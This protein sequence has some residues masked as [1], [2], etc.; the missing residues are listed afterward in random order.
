MWEAINIET[1]DSLVDILIFTFLIMLAPMVFIF[2]DLWSG[3]H[4]AKARGESITSKGYRNTVRKIARYYNV[5]FV[6][7]ALDSMQ[8]ACLGYMRIVGILDWI[9][10]PWLTLLGSIGVGLIE[11]KSVIEPADEKE[12]RRMNDILT[13]AK[14]IAA[15]KSEPAEIAEAV[16]AYLN[17]RSNETNKEGV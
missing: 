17:N 9:L 5:L 16:A 6:L 8:I 13:L 4:K 2:V 12:S 15:H 11:V 7:M 1:I 14:A 10:F 3:I